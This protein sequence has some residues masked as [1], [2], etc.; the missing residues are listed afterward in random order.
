MITPNT[1]VTALEILKEIGIK[2]AEDK[3]GKIRVRIGGLSGINTPD[4][5]VKIQPNTRAIEVIVGT[6]VYELNLA[7]GNAQDNKNIATVTE[8]AK[9]VLEKKGVEATKK[10]EELQTV[11]DI[12]KRMLEAEESGAEFTPTKEES[13][14]LEKATER[15][16][17]IKAARKAAKAEAKLPRNVIKVQS[18]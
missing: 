9:S 8:N 7:D 15:A 13:K 1:K 12:A 11:K 17:A 16:E 18:K 5:L 14:H 3:F 6:D 4:H 2:N 10:A